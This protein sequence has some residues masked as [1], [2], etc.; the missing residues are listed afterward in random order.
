MQFTAITLFALVAAVMANP[1]VPRQEAEESDQVTVET[2]AMTDSNG[3]IIPF[4][5]NTVDQPNLAAGL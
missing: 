4:D 5:S 1:L 2:P 3:N